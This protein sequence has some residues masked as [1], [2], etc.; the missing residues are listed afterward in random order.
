MT[1]ARGLMPL[2]AL[3]SV[4]SEAC[5]LTG[6]DPDA[7]SVQRPLVPATTTV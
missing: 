3:L 5:A 2:I 1:S 4:C 7:V 6:A